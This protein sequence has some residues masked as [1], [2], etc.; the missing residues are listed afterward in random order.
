MLIDLLDFCLASF[1]LLILRCFP[2]SSRERDTD[3]DGKINF[4][5]FFHGL[6]DLVR[7]YE[8][9]GHG[10][11]TTHHSDDPNETPAA[12]KLFNELDKDGDG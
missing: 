10:H 3:K 9:E 12:R 8:E 4:N 5:E 2:W 11:N 6:F 1:F 7:N